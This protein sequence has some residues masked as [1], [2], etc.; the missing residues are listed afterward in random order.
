M[1]QLPQFMAQETHTPIYV[2]VWL[3]SIVLQCGLFSALFARRIAGRAPFFTNLVGFYLVR[4]VVCFVLLNPL[5][6]HAYSELLHIFL[7]FEIFCQ[8]CVA[9]A[10]T[11]R[12]IREQGGW[13]VYR[14]AIPVALLLTSILA[15]HFTTDIEPPP[16]VLF[17]RTL[18]YFSYYMILVCGWDLAVRHLTDIG[19]PIIEGFALYGVINIAATIGR[20]VAF[21]NGNLRGYG[22]STYSLAASYVV[23]VIF[24]LVFLKPSDSYNAARAVGTSVHP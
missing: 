16:H 13:N 9:Y 8:V 10:L 15:T 6:L 12:L 2:V 17:D 11:D 24:W 21:H 5:S 22:A 1:H 19:R 14:A 4:S 7:L 3:L 20:I 18:L 23:A